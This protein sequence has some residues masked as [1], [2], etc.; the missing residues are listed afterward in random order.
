MRALG[1]VA[2]EALVNGAVPV[3][4]IN[5]VKAATL[6]EAAHHP[7]S[8]TVAVIMAGTG[9]DTFLRKLEQGDSESQAIIDRSGFYFGLALTNVIHL[10][11]PDTILIGGSTSRF[12]G[13]MDAALAAVKAYTLHAAA[14]SIVEAREPKRAVALGARAFIS[15]L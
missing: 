8:D 12:K 3:T 13:Y 11:N 15:R 10:Y 4:L 2:A 5:D 14:C 7:D 6:S 9:I 1:G